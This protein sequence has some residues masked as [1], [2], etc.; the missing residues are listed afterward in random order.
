MA[1]GGVGKAERAG[2]S[3]DGERWVGF[4][5]IIEAGKNGS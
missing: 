5:P 2:V 4:G 1:C 3:A